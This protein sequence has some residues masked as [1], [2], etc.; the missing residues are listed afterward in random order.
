VIALADAPETAAA[1]AARRDEHRAKAAAAE[2]A[3][4]TVK[5]EQ[6]AAMA[7]GD[8]AT[9]ARL[10]A[11]RVSHAEDVE[12]HTEAAALLEERHAEA[13]ERE[14][15]DAL[16]HAAAE[17][18]RLYAAA[19]AATID[20]DTVAHRHAPALAEAGERQLAAWTA[21]RTAFNRY[22]AMRYP[23]PV[24][25]E[26]YRDEI[27]FPAEPYDQYSRTPHRAAVLQT[28][29][30]AAAQLV[31]HHPQPYAALY[32]DAVDGDAPDADEREAA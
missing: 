29:T 25:R 2:Q 19:K 30:H 1:L 26:R 20:V 27:A 9:A 24:H 17:V 5:A 14:R 22:Q 4:A 13:V 3:L 11:V 7:A 12:A 21:A 18:E 31:A 6:A 10:R 23:N 15:A 32:P 8:T 16:T 28:L